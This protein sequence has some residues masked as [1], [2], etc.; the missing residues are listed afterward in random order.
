M[1]FNPNMVTSIDVPIVMAGEVNGM[2]IRKTA[3]G[4]S[5]LGGAKVVFINFSTGEK[6]EVV[7]FNNGEFY[8][9]GLIPGRY[10][11]QLDKSQLRGLD[12]LP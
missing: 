7:T 11:A 10:R 5:G 6:T 12:R 9:L 8:Y 1:N 3:R 4:Q 2:I